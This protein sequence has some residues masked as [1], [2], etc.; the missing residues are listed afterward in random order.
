MDE[1]EREAIRAEGLDSDDPAMVTAI[2]FVRWQR[3]FSV[4]R[5]P[6]TNPRNTTDSVPPLQLSRFIGHANV[7]DDLDRLCPPDQHR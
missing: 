6:A 7:H 3:C 5:T 2:D 4:I 1:T